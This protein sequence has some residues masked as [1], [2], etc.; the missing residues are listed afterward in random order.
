MES[1]LNAVSCYRDAGVDVPMYLPNERTVRH[2]LVYS[3][4]NLL[5][6]RLQTTKNGKYIIN[7]PLNTII[8]KNS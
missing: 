1:V 7:D 6:I 5:E 8:N 2:R 4:N 3:S